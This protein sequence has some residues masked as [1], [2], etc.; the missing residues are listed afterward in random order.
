MLGE[1]KS[2]Q[3]LNPGDITSNREVQAAIAEIQARFMVAQ[4]PQMKRVYEVVA[5]D[6]KELCERKGFAQEATYNVKVGSKFNNASGQWDDIYDEDFNIR[7]AEQFMIHY[8]NVSTNTVTVHEDSERRKVAISVTDLES[9]ITYGDEITLYKTVE[10][11]KLKQGQAAL[12]ERETSVAG[13]KVYIVACTP[14]ELQKKQNAQA[15]KKIRKMFFRL[16]PIELK[17]MAR[18]TI[19]LTIL[20]DIKKNIKDRRISMLESFK[21]LGIEPEEIEE[22]AEKKISNFD[23]QMILAMGKIYNGL[24]EGELRWAELLASK[25]TIEPD[26]PVFDP[27]ADLKDVP[28]A[29]KPEKK[30]E[31]K[32]VAEQ[33][34]KDAALLKPKKTATAKKEKQ[35][36]TQGGPLMKETDDPAEK[37]N[38]EHVAPDPPV[39][40]WVC[41]AH[42]EED[43]EVCNGAEPENTEEVVDP[44]PTK[45]K[46]E[47][48][49]PQRKKID[50]V[51]R[52]MKKLESVPEEDKRKLEQ[53]SY[54]FNGS[55][56][57]KDG[58]LFTIVLDNLEIAEALIDKWIEE[59]LT[60]GGV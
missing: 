5:A 32:T 33:E 2:L 17:M 14:E 55:F 53:K 40:G 12:S 11:K 21:S 23:E 16:F 52:I 59:N 29:K 35:K 26:A 18:E 39:K 3:T 25:E 24:K 8:R 58:E 48:S 45:E 22:Y 36:V 43:C 57:N 9:N 51:D 13:Q 31:D 20:S 54:M 19:D 34:K 10:R 38:K 49:T 56:D 15:S 4:L 7:A 46:A 50:A 41:E 60:E 27:E 42:G 44:E 1:N 30:E 37:I 6:I 47:K 28:D